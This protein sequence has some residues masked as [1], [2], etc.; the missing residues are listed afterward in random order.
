MQLNGYSARRERSGRYEIEWLM[1]SSRFGQEFL[2]E[3]PHSTLCDECKSA[4][5]AVE[6]SS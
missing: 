3:P 2:F 1:N 5:Q 6:E 4:L